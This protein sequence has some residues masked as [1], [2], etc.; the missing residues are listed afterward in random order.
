[1]RQDRQERR[2]PPA[3]ISW[4]LHPWAPESGNYRFILTTPLYGVYLPP[5]PFQS[6]A[7]MSSA[8]LASQR[9]SP[10]FPVYAGMS[11]I[12]TLPAA[13]REISPACVGMCGDEPDRHAYMLD[14][15][16]IIVYLFR[17]QFRCMPEKA[18]SQPTLA[19]HYRLHHTVLTSNLPR[20]VKS[21]G[22]FKRRSDCSERPCDGPR[23]SP[24]TTRISASFLSDMAVLRKQ[25]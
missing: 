5:Q 11:L 10:G 7:G 22:I 2:S 6:C 8:Y 1:M 13:R 24:N 12:Y 23:V 17:T 4:R 9:T 15:G 16:H 21:M 20:V 19:V 3:F 14:F 25:R 18:A